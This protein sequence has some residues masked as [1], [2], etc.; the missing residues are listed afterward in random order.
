MATRG[1]GVD[2]V[3]VERFARVLTRRPAL[4]ERLFTT[5]ERDDA[6]GRPER[7]AARFAAK[8]AVLKALGGGLGD[9]R[10]HDIEVRRTSSGA[11]EL[12]LGDATQR[13]AA[14]RGVQEWHLSLS[15]TDA[16]AMAVVIASGDDHA[17]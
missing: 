12:V 16:T 7:L 13:L 14:D 9:S 4:A 11:P 17:S 2:V 10:W 8:E 6:A 1:V 5:R 3:D 15:H